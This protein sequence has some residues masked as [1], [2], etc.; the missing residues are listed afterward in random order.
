VALARQRDRQN[1]AVWNIAA[2]GHDALAPA[3]GAVVTYGGGCQAFTKELCRMV[4]PAKFRPDLPQRYDGTA[5]PVE[6]LH[7]YTIS[8][9]A[10]RGNDKAMMNWFPMGLKDAI[11][12]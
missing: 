6:F 10:A 9:Q 1:H 11:H 5:N 12:L 3:T 7:L 8:V 4:W 2:V